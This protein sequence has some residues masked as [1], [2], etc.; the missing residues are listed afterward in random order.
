MNQQ[1]NLN[2]RIV[3]DI[4]AQLFWLLAESDGVEATS[5]AVIES[6]G[7][8]LVESPFAASVLSQYGF[9][10]LSPEEQRDAC[11]AIAEEA[12]TFTI[13]GEN[14]NGIVYS[15]D[16]A[17]GRAPSAQNVETAHLKVLPK[18]LIYSG[19]TLE[20]TGRLCLRHPLPAVVFTDVAPRGGVFE[21]ADTSYALGFHLPMFLFNVATTQLDDNLY[22]SMGIF[23]IPVPDSEHGDQWA[24]A[25]G[26]ST[27]F[28][29]RLQLIGA[30][31]VTTVDVTW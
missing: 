31:G 9:D 8:C 27:R 4:A 11:Q 6:G 22:V 14:L 17:E 29:D 10:Q 3:H 20:K 5:G 30:G 1:R 23:H 28:I 12:E 25:I 7:R 16:A 2:P 15:E 26:N 13:K 21:V 18:D 19:Q 24:R